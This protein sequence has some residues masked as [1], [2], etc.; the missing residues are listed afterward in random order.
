VNTPSH[1]ILNLALLGTTVAPNANIAITLGAIVPDLPIFVFYFVA[2]FVLKLP[3]G[4]IW[5]EAY[6][7]PFWQTLVALFHSIP[8]AA[9]A[10]LLCL[11]G[12]WK[13]GAIFFGSAILHSLLDLPVH[14]DDAHRHFFPFSDYRFISPISYWD[15]KHYGNIIACIELLLVLAVTPLVF[16]LLKTW[17]SKILLLAINLVYVI[18][19]FRFYLLSQFS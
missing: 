13:P 16:G 1:Y 3:E 6:Y 10:L 15:P 17:T 9:I 11:Y 5:S 14:H 2:K 4:Q 19:Y 18:G 8:L 7:Q 12:G